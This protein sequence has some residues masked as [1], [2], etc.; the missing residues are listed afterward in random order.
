MLGSGSCSFLAT[1]ERHLNDLTTRSLNDAFLGHIKTD[2]G[3]GGL[4]IVLP[5]VDGLV[6]DSA[7]FS[8]T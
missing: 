3:F 5:G 2:L 7:Y 6:R 8:N 4:R 1:P